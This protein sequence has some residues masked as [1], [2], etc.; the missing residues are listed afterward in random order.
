MSGDTRLM[1]CRKRCSNKSRSAADS[2]AKR[3]YQWREQSNYSQS[4]AALRLQVSKRTLQEWEQ[5]RATPA[6]LALRAIESAIGQPVKVARTRQ[7]TGPRAKR[8]T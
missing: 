6:H 2:L 5:A 7:S 1:A 8:Y 3:L 4:R